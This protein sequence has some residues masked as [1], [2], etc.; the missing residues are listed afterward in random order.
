MNLHNELVDRH[1]KSK[2][3][4]LLHRSEPARHRLRPHLQ[5]QRVVWGQHH[6]RIH[7]KQTIAASGERES[8]RTL[9]R[10]EIGQMLLCRFRHQLKTVHEADAV[11][12][13][14]GETDL[15]D[16]PLIDDRLQNCSR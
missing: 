15:H 14:G 4:R 2:V 13:T 3:L 16:D 8:E 11:A 10:D 12:G 6:K 7:R 5:V 9:G 1:V